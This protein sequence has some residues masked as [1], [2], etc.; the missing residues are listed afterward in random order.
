MTRT[1]DVTLVV[2]IVFFMCVL[3]SLLLN[4]YF[5]REMRY[6]SSNV[7]YGHDLI[8]TLGLKIELLHRENVCDN[9]QSKSL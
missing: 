8:N 5:I 1:F 4:I 7:R 2:F 3:S 9:H 6:M